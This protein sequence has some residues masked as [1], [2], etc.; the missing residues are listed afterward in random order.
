MS[1]LIRCIPINN[2]L[3]LFFHLLIQYLLSIRLDARNTKTLLHGPCPQGMCSSVSKSLTCKETKYRV[4]NEY[5][6]AQTAHSKI[7]FLKWGITKVVW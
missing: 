2:E 3:N 7:I 4:F 1:F 5:S 6:E